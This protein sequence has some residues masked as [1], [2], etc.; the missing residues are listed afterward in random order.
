LAVV[1]WLI[2]G[3]I[4]HKK[5][6][7]SEALEHFN[8]ALQ[9]ANDNVMEHEYFTDITLDRKAVLNEICDTIP[10]LEQSTVPALSFSFVL[11]HMSC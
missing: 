4:L 10:K 1:L 2:K 9:L 11:P 8:Q 3:R 5:E 7:Y 6:R